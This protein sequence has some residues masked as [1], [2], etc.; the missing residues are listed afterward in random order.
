MAAPKPK[1][2]WRHGPALRPELLEDRTAPATFTIANG[3]VPGLV[4]AIHA[5]DGNGQDNT[6]VLARGGS[7]VLGVVDNAADGPTGLPVVATGGH[8]LTIEGNGAA[9]ERGT[10]AGTPAFRLLDV[11]AESVL[12]LVKLTLADG[13]ET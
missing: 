7:Y 10:A 1:S 6:I 3:D 5:A 12:D 13:M 11:A 4:A 8:A 9:I 2:K